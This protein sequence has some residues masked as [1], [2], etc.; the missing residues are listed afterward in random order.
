MTLGKAYEKLK[1]I[2]E[3]VKYLDAIIDNGDEYLTGKE[4]TDIRELLA[5]YIN[6][7]SKREI[8]L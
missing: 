7:L 5:E 6:L 2:E 1:K 3:M 4:L 8:Y